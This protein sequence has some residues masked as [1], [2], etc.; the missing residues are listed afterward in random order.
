MKI[1]SIYHK[2]KIPPNVIKHHFEVTAVGRHLCDNW[3]GEKVDKKLVTQTL[4]LH[5]M[6]NIIKFKKPFM[7]E[8]NKEVAYWEGVQQEYIAKYG[9]DVHVATMAIVGELELPK[10]AK[11]IDQMHTVWTEPE[12]TVSFEARI[13]E[14]AD[15]CAAP[16]G[17]VSLKERLNDLKVRYGYTDD[18]GPIVAARHNADVVLPYLSQPLEMLINHDF[19]AEIEKLKTFKF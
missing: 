19:S 5:D 16:S 2:Y 17:I 9:N 12:K 13:C 3:L 7:G 11:L 8:L 10:I 15:C 6:G 14:L 4:L 18:S 1:S